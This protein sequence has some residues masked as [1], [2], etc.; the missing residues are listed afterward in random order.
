[1]E[2]LGNKIREGT[3]TVEEV[4]Q[5][6]KGKPQEEIEVDVKESLSEEQAERNKELMQRAKEGDVLAANDLVQ[7]NSGLILRLLMKIEI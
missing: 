7:E 1:M 6:Q 5:V 3:L 4:Q 2:S